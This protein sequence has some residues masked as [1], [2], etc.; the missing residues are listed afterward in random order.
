M[1]MKIPRRLA[2]WILS[3]SGARFSKR[4]DREKQLLFSTIQGGTVLEIGPGDGGNLPYLANPRNISY[5]GVEPNPFLR[6]RT[7]LRA[8]ELNFPHP[9]LLSG[10]AED[11]PCRAGSVDA[12]ISTLVL[13]SVPSPARAVREIR[14]V[15]S[16]GGTFYFIEHVAAPAGTL[17]CF[18]QRVIKPFTLW[19]GDGCH[20]DRSTLEVIRENGFSKISFSRLVLPRLPLSP[21]IIGTAVK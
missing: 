2:A 18:G 13:C 14:R 21:L 7:W 11:I 6:E 12:L 3:K 15:L 1:N 20:P 8:L 9:V 16:P 10:A 4:L 19:C 17:A 5:I